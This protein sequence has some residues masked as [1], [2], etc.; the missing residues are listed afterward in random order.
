LAG[1]LSG[2]TSYITEEKLMGDCDDLN[3]ALLIGWEGFWATSAFLILLPIFQ[4][5]PCSNTSI[6]TGRVV[7]DTY[8]VFQDYGANPIL[9]LQSFGIAFFTLSI[10]IVGAT[11]TKVGSAA[12]RTVVD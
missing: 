12:Q 8:L 1:Q 4:F 7:E 2:A 6:C 3:P 11:I 10:N 5:I 9:I